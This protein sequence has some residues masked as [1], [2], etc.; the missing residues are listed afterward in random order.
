MWSQSTNVTDRQTDGR[1]DKILSA[2]KHNACKH[3]V[4]SVVQTWGSHTVAEKITRVFLVSP[5]PPVNLLFHRLWQQKGTV[6]ITFIKVVPYKCQQIG[7]SRTTHWDH[8][9]PVYLWTAVLHKYLND[10]TTLFCLLQFFPECCTKFH[11]DFSSFHV[12]R[13]SWIYS[14]YSS[15][16]VNIPWVAVR[17][18]RLP[19]GQRGFQRWT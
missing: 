14:T 12:W 7:H 3:Q 4:L 9:D 16:Y 19:S 11:D 5:E 1:T 8:S 2:L 15:H 6:T 18:L 10:V 13:N 17:S